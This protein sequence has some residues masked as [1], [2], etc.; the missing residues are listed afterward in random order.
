MHT[1]KTVPKLGV[2]FEVLAMGYH[3]LAQISNW[4]YLLLI[5]D[6]VALGQGFDVDGHRLVQFIHT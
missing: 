1:N 4:Q 3:C 2:W 6:F 5:F